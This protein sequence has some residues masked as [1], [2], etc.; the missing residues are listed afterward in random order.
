MDGAPVAPG[1]FGAGGNLTL[2]SLAS[3][4]TALPL[5]VVTA[6]LLGISVF[7]IYPG[8]TA[9]PTSVRGRG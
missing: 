8:T 5:T 7:T 9:V 2:I 3:D 6:G 4:T 1:G